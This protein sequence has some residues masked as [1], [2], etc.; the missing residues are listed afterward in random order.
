MVRIGIIIA[1]ACLLLVSCG[2]SASNTAAPVDPPAAALAE[3]D[4][5]ACPADVDPELWAGLK[6]TLRATLVD[7]NLDRAASDVAQSALSRVE[8]L[9]V[10]GVE[11]GT[12]RLNWS[13]RNQ[14]DYNQDGEVGV[15]DLTPIGQNWQAKASDATWPKSCV[16]DG[17]ADGLV[18]VNDITPIGQC[19]LRTVRGY[20]I[21]TSLTPEVED[22][23]VD[24]DPV[25]LSTGVKPAGGGYIEFTYDLHPIADGTYLRVLPYCDG[26]L[27]IASNAIQYCGLKPDA[28]T[29]LTASQGTVIGSVELSW[30][31]GN[32][33]LD[34]LIERA[35]AEEG[36][37]TQI[38]TVANPVTVLSDNDVASGTHYW[39]R[40]IAQRGADQSEPSAATEGWPVLRDWFH[41]WG[42]PNRDLVNG[43]D[44]G[45]DGRIYLAGEAYVD[46]GHGWCATVA[47]YN[48]NG[49]L[50]WV[51]Q[52]EGSEDDELYDVLAIPEGHVYACGYTRNGTE[53][54]MAMLLV[55]LTST[56]EIQHEFI[57]G[58]GLGGT[59]YALAAAGDGN[60]L[61][62]GDG[63]VDGS[64]QHVVLFKLD[65]DCNLL[66]GKGWG[67]NKTQSGYD[68]AV[69][70]SGDI[71]IGGYLYDDS[72]TIHMLMLKLG[73]DG[74]P[75][76]Q[77]AF[78]F[79]G[80]RLKGI[81][82]DGFGNIYLAGFYSG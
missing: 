60:I 1:V 11:G 25:P 31:A 15:A 13:Y 23:W 8:D 27:G 10:T 17:N 42:G 58:D 45:P 73:S 3:L 5:L 51:R 64:D 9:A 26:V 75:L 56:G 32:G 20:R 63:D 59:A 49:Q 28:V 78:T 57:W 47:C 12:A 67:G 18:S 33:E 62:L 46:G 7:A 34:Y 53:D 19:W 71:Y 55:E 79:G 21:Q 16:A 30:Q 35:Q 77:K 4:S 61:L 29:Q 70:G 66:W 52:L 54:G 44:I 74:S 81:D 14:G 22:S 69:D 80:P 41:T 82:V 38:G 68:V 40:V 50:E 43:M 2:G 65:P 6:S 37:Y 72:S 48:L 76:L 36:P 39:Y 24:S